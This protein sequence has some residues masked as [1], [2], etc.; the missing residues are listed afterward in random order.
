MLYKETKPLPSKLI[1]LTRRLRDWKQVHV[2]AQK[3]SFRAP[4]P[5]QTQKGPIQLAQSPFNEF[6]TTNNT[7]QT[8]VT[9]NFS[10]PELTYSLN[11]VNS[12][13]T[14]NEILARPSLVAISGQKSEFFP[15]KILRR[16]LFPQQQNLL[17]PK[18]NPLE[19]LIN[20]SLSCLRRAFL[21]T[22]FGLRLYG[23]R[24]R[25]RAKTVARF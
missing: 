3:A 5:N 9:R 1:H 23:K 21:N 17:Q 4:L 8:I 12:G 11:I 19:I 18:T 13:S 16:Q 14:R 6:N 20:L 15:A 22:R 24:K 7:T 25:L 2:R 10:I